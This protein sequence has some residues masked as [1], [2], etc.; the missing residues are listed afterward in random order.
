MKKYFPGWLMDEEDPLVLAAREATA[1]IRGKESPVGT[2]R[3]STN[4]VS[5]MGRDGIPAIG[6]GPGR[7]EMAH[8]PNE[9]VRIEDLTGACL[10]YA[11]LPGIYFRIIQ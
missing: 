3:F 11:Y 6:S 1:A 10:F 2:W 5:M 8:R 9:R 4:G 7:E